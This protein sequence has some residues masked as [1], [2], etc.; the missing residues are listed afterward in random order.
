MHALI[1]Q[2]KQIVQDKENIEGHGREETNGTG[3]S[4]P[5]TETTMPK[6]NERCDVTVGSPDPQQRRLHKEW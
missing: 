2:P 3:K 4:M 1:F 6:R 5:T